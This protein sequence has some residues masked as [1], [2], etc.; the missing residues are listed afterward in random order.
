LVTALVA[1]VMTSTASMNTSAAM[2]T[3]KKSHTVA[4]R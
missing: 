1:D 2:A 3:P 4:T